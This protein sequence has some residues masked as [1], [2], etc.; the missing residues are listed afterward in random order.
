M[1]CSSV[2]LILFLMACNKIGNSLLQNQK[3]SL[4]FV[5]LLV[6]RVEV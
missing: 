4:F 6:L 5:L 3:F 2:L 1:L